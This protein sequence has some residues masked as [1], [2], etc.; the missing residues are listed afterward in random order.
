MKTHRIKCAP[1]Y[2]KALKAG[3]KTFEIRF[4]DRDYK[5]NDL[6]FINEFDGQQTDN[7]L[8]FKIIYILKDYGL[9]N[10]FV[11]LGIKPSS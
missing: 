7:V 9:Q 5:V 4:N 1:E 10:G 8:L 6:L 11:C 2:F 3:T